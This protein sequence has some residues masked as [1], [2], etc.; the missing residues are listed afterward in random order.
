MSRTSG[1][2]LQ[3]LCRLYQVQTAYADAEHRRKRTPDEA[4][5]R[6]LAGLGA[7]V[8]SIHDVPAALREQ[9]LA[10]WRRFVDP[11]AVTWYGKPFSVAVR[12]PFDKTSAAIS[13]H[14]S[15]ENGTEEEYRWNGA[16]LYSEGVQ[17]VD[18]TRFVE[19]RL[20]IASTLPLG[21][22]RLT[23]E[24]CG[25]TASCL[26]I[27]APQ[28]AFT[29][30]GNKTWGLFMPL[31][32]LYT[33]A[34]WGVGD[35]SDLE[36]FAMWS[37]QMGSDVVATLPL[38]P[39]FLD[40]PF[41]PSPYAPVS[42]L[43]WNEIYVDVRSAPEF[44]ECRPARA[45]VGSQGFQAQINDLRS[46]PLVDYRRE[47]TM[48]RGVLEK[49]ASFFFAQDTPRRRSF[50]RFLA[51]NPHVEAYARFRSV[52]E[53][54]RT[55]WTR[56]PQRLRTGDVLEGDCDQKTTQYYLYAQWLAHDQ[57][58]SL[59][60]W[61]GDTG[62]ALYLDMPLGVHPL[63]YD[64]WRYQ[65][66]FIRDLSAG[67]P[68]D[69]FYAKGQDWGFPPLHPEK[70]R[71]QGYGYYIAYIRHHLRHCGILRMDHVMALHRLWWIPEGTEADSGAYVR[72]HAEEL[73]AILIL[74]SHRHKSMIVGE[75]LG[76]V[77]SYVNR[78]MA[79]HGINGMF[80]VPFQIK[81]KSRRPLSPVPSRSVASMNTHDMPTFASFSQGTDIDERLE[82][83]QVH[84]RDVETQHR[85]RKALLG[86]LV[87]SLVTLGWLKQTSR[88]PDDVLSA[89]LSF[90]AASESRLVL[91]NLE[92]LWLETAPQNVPGTQT[93]RPN[94]L[95]KARYSFEEFTKLPEVV[96]RLVAIDRLRKS[97]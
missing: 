58:R 30:R 28:R 60:K 52:A 31:Y 90:L 64:A 70:I 46:S 87:R 86:A 16:S 4:L 62:M 76:T 22:H 68:P 78:A 49:L 74:E 94:W 95:R 92:D 1:S 9:T 20:P 10:T 5:I 96:D 59:S 93:E 89:C 44:R 29:P 97:K 45:V 85:A 83:G 72:Y 43:L 77:P 42:R 33:T 69:S 2:P 67:A 55:P 73:Y 3:R 37:R 18:G 79:R 25:E 14:L 81:P 11:V 63:G 91:V 61:A 54:Q 27:S 12:I 15:L 7:P 40:E 39:A 23:L 26:V 88:A 47:M 24:L 65:D 36:T 21:Y 51:A 19:K 53:R 13:G 82:L 6:V 80:V 17:D 71:E 57:M 84:H 32:S 66:L 38:L 34:S 35:L 8:A 50:E 56:W 41:D 75:N 48:K